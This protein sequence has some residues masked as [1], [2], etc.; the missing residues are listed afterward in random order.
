M[1][2]IKDTTSST[3]CVYLD[4]EGLDISKQ[5]PNP[6]LNI[7]PLLHFN[8]DMYNNLKPSATQESFDITFYY[9]NLFLETLNDDEKLFTHTE[10]HTL[11]HI[12]TERDTHT[13]TD[14]H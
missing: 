10:R 3:A 7:E 14:T 9:P 6:S 13:D 12:H 11:K 2:F 1:K 5:L 8:T 4:L